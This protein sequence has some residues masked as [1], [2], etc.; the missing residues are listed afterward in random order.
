[1]ARSLGKVAA[2]VAVLVIALG[3]AVE[4][5]FW[6][7]PTKITQFDLGQEACPAYSADMNTMYFASDTGGG[8]GHDI[9]R[10]TRGATGWEAPVLVSE[11]N[12]SVLDA[13]PFPTYDG[14]ALYFDSNGHGGEGNRDIFIATPSGSG[15]GD[16]QNLGSNVNSSANDQEPCFSPYGPTLYFGSD[17]GT[18]RDIWQSV[19]DSG[20][21]CWGPASAVPNINSTSIE[22]APSVSRD[23]L[24]MYFTS[25]RS[26][27]VY[28]LYQSARNTV[29]DQWGAPTPLPITCTG[30]HQ[31]GPSFW[32]EYG[33]LAT[34]QYGG[35]TGAWNIYEAEWIPEPTT[36][37][38]LGAGLLALCRRRRS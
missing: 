2:T 29:N 37:V 16:I 30:T 36:I 18:S 5:G 32:G 3:A 34:N 33:T 13:G 19:W 15:W 17:R 28:R 27:N 31:S 22:D 4:A 7:V 20:N 24:L 38:L 12:T 26:G 8:T 10:S 6:G 9:Y 11:L 14:T 23:G 21:D 1:M 25:K 35:S